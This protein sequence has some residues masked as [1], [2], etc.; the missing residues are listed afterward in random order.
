MSTLVSDAKQLSVN[1]IKKI[2]DINQYKQNQKKEA[3]RAIKE[4][5][6]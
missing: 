6:K 1:E 4:K 5:E 3:N 2:V